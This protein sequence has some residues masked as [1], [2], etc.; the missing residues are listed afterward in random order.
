MRTSPIIAYAPLYNIRRE[1]PCQPC[2]IQAKRVLEP[3]ERFL[4]VSLVLG[5]FCV[6]FLVSTT[7]NR[8]CIFY[9][10]NLFVSEWYS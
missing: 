10:L 4:R 9:R 6:F 8:S 7:Q 5:D 2:E 1:K 3:L